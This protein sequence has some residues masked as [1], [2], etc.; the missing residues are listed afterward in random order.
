[1]RISSLTRFRTCHLFLQITNIQENKCAPHP[2]QPWSQLAQTFISAV[3]VSP[4]QFP[5]TPQIFTMTTLEVMERLDELEKTMIEQFDR[6]AK[7]SMNTQSP[8]ED[9][10][11]LSLNGV[12]WM[13]GS[14]SF[15]MYYLGVSAFISGISGIESHK[16]G[17]AAAGV[18]LAIE[19]G[20]MVVIFAWG[21]T[22][23]LQ[24]ARKRAMVMFVSSTTCWEVARAW[25]CPA[26]QSSMATWAPFTVAFVV[27]IITLDYMTAKPAEPTTEM[28]L[29]VAFGDKRNL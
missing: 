28:K 6:L 23:K 25:V 21:A 7:T 14:S 22:S 24:N 15:F 8:Q 17:F 29:P 19:L 27:T 13:A 1:M 10:S 12:V 3:H 20:L 26:M 11:D 18:L 2:A 16:P 4:A 9:S 5:S